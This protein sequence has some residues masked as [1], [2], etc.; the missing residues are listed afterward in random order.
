ML[1]LAEQWGWTGN[2][3]ETHL[4]KLLKQM[5]DES[6]PKLPFGYIKLDEA[7]LHGL[8]IECNFIIDFP[9]MFLGSKPCKNKLSS[10]HD[11][12]ERPEQGILLV[13]SFR[14]FS[15][16]ISQETESETDAVHLLDLGCCRRDMLL[17]GHTLP[18]T[19]LRQTAQ[20]QSPLGLQR[21]FSNVERLE[22]KMDI[23]L[24]RAFWGKL[25]LATLPSNRWFY[26]C[27]HQRRI[28]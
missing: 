11:H 14:G 17:A 10:P 4:G 1:N 6:D 21:N 26:P 3:T 13:F 15:I 16:V 22:T 20:W 7:L 8:E 19:Q 25:H 28:N 18:P 2:D 24:P 12:D 5:I 9:L 23:L 27:A